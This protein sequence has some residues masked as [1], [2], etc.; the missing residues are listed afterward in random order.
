MTPIAFKI[1]Y[2]D[3]TTRTSKEGAWDAIDTPGL[4]IAMV[5]VYFKET[6]EQWVQD[7]WS[8]SGVPINQRLETKNYCEQLQGEDFYW[9]TT[10]DGA[11]DTWGMGKAEDAPVLSPVNTVKTGGALPDET[12]WP[13]YNAAKEERVAP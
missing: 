4:D 2:A 3:G 7:G 11:I 9:L 10:K 8:E 1:W 6:Y 12:W 5:T 13:L